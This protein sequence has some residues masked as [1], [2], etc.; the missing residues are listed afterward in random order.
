MSPPPLNNA[1]A[2]ETGTEKTSFSASGTLKLYPKTD[3][4]L[5]FR[6]QKNLFLR[7]SRPASV[8][9]LAPGKM[10]VR[11]T[12]ATHPHAAINDSDSNYGTLILCFF[13]VCLGLLLL[14]ISIVS[15]SLVL[16]LSGLGIS[17][18]AFLYALIAT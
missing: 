1:T 2:L 14:L 7:K 10:Q 4:S 11:S 12:R 15:S 17:L 6:K 16:A 5:S 8:L 18:C 3:G 13:G 9:T